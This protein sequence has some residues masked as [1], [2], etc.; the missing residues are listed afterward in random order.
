LGLTNLSDMYV[1]SYGWSEVSRFRSDGQAE[2]LE[3]GNWKLEFGIWDLEFGICQRY[4]VGKGGLPPLVWW[5]DL[6]P[7]GALPF[8]A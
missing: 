7:S 5:H 3:T 6:N 8:S 4:Q 1:H 2:G